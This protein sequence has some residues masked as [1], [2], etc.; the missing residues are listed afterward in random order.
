MRP[1]SK[2]ARD[3]ALA[4][5][6]VLAATSARAA[7]RQFSYD[8]ADA[9]TRAAAGPVTLVINQTMFGTRVLKLRSTLAKAT[10]DLARADIGALGRDAWSRAV[11][12]KAPERDLY[13]ILPGDDGA[14]FI[15]AL[16][17]GSKRGWL[18]LTSVR[19]G[20]DV[21]AVVI[22]DDPAGGPARRC[23]A[24]NFTFHGE[25][26]APSQ[27]QIEIDPVAPPDFP[28]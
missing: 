22:G 19:Y 27:R 5:A 17:P 1:V 23:R 3:S 12:A 10:A 11:G 2:R 4:L 9:E 16:C 18:A 20:D 26:R 14:A 7:I 13:R 21:Q 15:A 6:L 24:L 25:W 8:P 28:N